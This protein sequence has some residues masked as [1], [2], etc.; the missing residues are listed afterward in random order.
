MFEHF[1]LY[2]ALVEGDPD[3]D[4]YKKTKV[5]CAYLLNKKHQEKKYK[6]KKICIHPL[7]ENRKKGVFHTLVNELQ[8]DEV[9]FKVM[10]FGVVINERSNQL[11]GHHFKI[12]SV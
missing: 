9:N 5:I 4:L 11:H 3:H 1:S 7:L 2:C 6:K 8:D 10:Y 12:L